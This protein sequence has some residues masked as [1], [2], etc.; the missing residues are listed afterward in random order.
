MVARSASAAT[1]TGGCQATARVDTQWGSGSTGGE[2]VTITVANTAAMTATTWSVTWALSGDQRIVN[3]WNAT[4]SSSG[5]TVTAVNAAWNG[6]L[7]PGAATTFGM[8]LA[9]TAP[10]PVLSCG[11]DAVP[12]SSPP[13]SSSASSS[14]PPASGD[15][16]VT[17]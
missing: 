11:S 15:V 5:D 17:P 6:T 9:G 16:N 3:A 12:T 7:A 10:A 13:V 2:I 4:V 1:V 8:Q 14:S